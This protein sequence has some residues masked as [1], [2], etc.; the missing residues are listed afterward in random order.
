MLHDCHKHLK[1]QSLN[2]G[3]LLPRQA[4]LVL[5]ELTVPSGESAVASTNRPHFC[6]LI[7][8]IQHAQPLDF[9]AD[10]TAEYDIW[11]R[12]ATEIAG[13]SMEL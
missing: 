11:R 4:S 13:S 12:S 7:P 10:P 5:P 8:A 9:E 2:H 1:Q 3:L 6:F